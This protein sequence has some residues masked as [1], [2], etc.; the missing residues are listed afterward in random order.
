MVVMAPHLM[1]VVMPQEVEEEAQE[2]EALQHLQQLEV[3]E[4]QGCLIL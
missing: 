1:L 3:M 2:V 4:E